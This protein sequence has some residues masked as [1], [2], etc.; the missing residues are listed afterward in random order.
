M[1]TTVGQH[2]EL[3]NVI[4]QV[5]QEEK[6]VFTA[7]I[8]KLLEIAAPEFVWRITFIAFEVIDGEFLTLTSDIEDGDY[9]EFEVSVALLAKVLN[10]EVKE[11]ETTLLT[12][13]PLKAEITL[14]GSEIKDLT[15][16]LSF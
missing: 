14:R 4:V 15:V 7:S 6:S 16:V 1:K 13:L 5:Y 2:I 3:T 11:V 10:C 12:K 9:P 8:T